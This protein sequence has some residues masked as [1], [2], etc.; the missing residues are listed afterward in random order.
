MLSTPSRAIPK[1]LSTIENN[2]DWTEFPEPV[3]EVES[4]LA[5]VSNETYHIPAANV[6]QLDSEVT[7]EFFSIVLGP[8]GTAYVQRMQALVRTERETIRWAITT[9]RRNLQMEYDIGTRQSR[10]REHPMY[11]EGASI[12]QLKEMWPRVRAGVAKQS[13]K[14]MKAAKKRHEEL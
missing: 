10:S 6:D 1:S 9:T 5:H 14:T 11:T 2:N 8:Y 3:D 4:F 12:V 13:E 7:G